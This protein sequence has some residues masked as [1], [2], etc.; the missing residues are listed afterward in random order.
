MPNDPWIAVPAQRSSLVR[1]CV[2]AAFTWRRSY[3][4]PPPALKTAGVLASVPLGAPPHAAP[5]AQNQ[6][7]KHAVRAHVVAAWPMAPGQRTD[8]KQATQSAALSRSARH[9]AP[10]RVRPFGPNCRFAAKYVPGNATG[11]QIPPHTQIAA[12]PEGCRSTSRLCLAEETTFRGRWPSRSSDFTSNVQA[13]SVSLQMPHMHVPSAQ[14]PVAA[15]QL[16]YRR[17]VCRQPGSALTALR[18]ACPPMRR[19]RR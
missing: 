17:R 10:T 4:R 8:A 18:S 6:V 1:Y 14:A 13:S 2:Q 16:H 3:V 9:V 11:F 15:F 5:L 19:P 7:R 12:V